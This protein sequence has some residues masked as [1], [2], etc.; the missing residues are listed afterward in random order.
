MD[1]YADFDV[2]LLHETDRAY[3]VTETI[4]EMGFW[5]PKSQCQLEETS[6]GGIYTLSLPEWL[7]VEKG[8][9]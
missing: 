8:L 2:Q 7:A 6:V 4:P 5:I 9:L 1:D 3:L